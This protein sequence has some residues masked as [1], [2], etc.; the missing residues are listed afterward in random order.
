MVSF[1]RP[2]H[3][4]SYAHHKILLLR[5]DKCIEIT[6]NNSRS[7]KINLLDVK[8]YGNSHSKDCIRS[9]LFEERYLQIIP[10]PTG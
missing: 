2:Q 4:M 9:L 5:F 6:N 7:S 10:D 1:Q 3:N 8:V